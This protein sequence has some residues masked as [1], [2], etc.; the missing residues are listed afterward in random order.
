MPLTPEQKNLLVDCARSTQFAAKALFPNRFSRPFDPIH[1]KIFDLLDNSDSQQK[2]IAV[3]RGLGKTSI[4]N[5]LVPAIAILL[6]RKNYIVPVQLSKDNAVDQT[7]NLKVK[8]TQNRI[9]K[10]IYGD[11]KG[12]MW[13]KEKWICKVGSHE[14]MVRPR[15]AGTQIR[16]LLFRDS[17]PDLIVVDDLEDPEDMDSPQQRKKKKKW[18][19]ADLMNSIDRA[20]NDWEIVVLGTILHQDSLLM[21]LLDSP[22][23][24]SISLELCDDS[25]NTNAPNFMSSEEVR[26]LHESFKQDGELDVFYREYRNNPNVGGEDA[27]FQPRFFENKYSEAEHDLNLDPDVDNI[28]IVDPSRTATPR[29]NPSGIVG[30]GAN[31][32]THEI[33]VRECVSKRLHPGELYDEIAR[34]INM[35]QADVLAV[36]V[37]GLHEFVT[38]PMQTFLL[39]RNISIPLIELQAREGRTEKGKTARVRGLVDFYRQ[40]LMR[41][42]QSG[43]CAPL[44]SQLLSFPNAKEWSL[45]DPL[46][47][48]TEILEKGERYLSPNPGTNEFNETREEVES[49][50]QE[51]RDRYQDKALDNFRVF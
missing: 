37:T 42:N 22:N 16:G 3:P 41:H 5:L 20:S 40:G 49:E 14:V 9:I 12:S 7:E 43:V 21:N 29:S 34:V 6:Q 39:Q 36:E 8:L 19:Y 30:V 2:A 17:R 45:M 35:I 44:E 4:V 27:A 38:H 25:F 50:F 1:S 47:Y 31:M 23:W 11:I 46:G 32:Q 18:F 28:V 51:L 26:K 24:D 13:S 10:Q 15:G 33:F 48:I